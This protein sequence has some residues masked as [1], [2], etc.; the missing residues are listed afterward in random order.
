MTTA[1]A[2]KAPLFFD[3][4]AEMPVV[5]NKDGE[6][7]SLAVGDVLFY[8]VS[9]GWYGSTGVES[10]VTKIT[11][12]AIT[13]IARSYRSTKHRLNLSHL[14]EFDLN[15]P[16]DLRSYQYG[17]KQ[18]Y[19]LSA[20]DAAVIDA[21]RKARQDRRNSLD[22]KL[23]AAS[24][25]AATSP[26][27]EYMLRE[28]RTAARNKAH[29]IVMARYAE[30]IAAEQARIDAELV[31]EVEAQRPATKAWV[32]KRDLAHD[33]AFETEQEALDFITEYVEVNGADASGLGTP[34]YQTV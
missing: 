2:A 8:S 16:E 28:A 29:E 15:S 12:R 14:P 22:A 34:T 1:S 9:D 21:D 3:V 7:R 11:D 23:A 30:E 32:V 19:V 31:A 25:L 4:N 6:V 17:R 26:A 5:I 24:A 20:A 18:V 27:R 33:L 13:S 10:T